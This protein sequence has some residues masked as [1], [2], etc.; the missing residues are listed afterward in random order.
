MQSENLTFRRA[1]L[2]ALAA[3]ANA[4][5]A[6][7]A[8]SGSSLEE[9]VVTGTRIPIID[10]TVPN[11]TMSISS[12]SIQLSG[13]TNLT[14]LLSNMPALVGSQDTTQNSGSLAGIGTT[15]LNLLNLRNLGTD[16][17]LV[18]VDGRRHVAQVPESAAVD[19]DTIPIDLVE[20]V[21]VATGGVSAVYG[22]DAVSGVVNFI[23]K[24]DF[25]GVSARAQYGSGDSGKPVNTIMSLTAGTN[26]AEGR[27]N[28]S[29]SFEVTREG[30]L[31][32]A[33]R[34]YLS[35]ANY[36]RLTRLGND[37]P[38][39]SNL[40]DRVALNNIR[41]Y[42]DSREGGIDVGFTGVP[43][44]RPDGSLYDPGNI[45]PGGLAQGGNGTLVADYI[46]DVIAGTKN[47]IAS[48]FLHYEFSDRAKLFGELKYAHGNSYS[49]SQPTFDN[50]VY[51]TAENPY[52]S[53][54]ITA[55][56]APGSGASNTGITGAPDGVLFDRDNFD[57]G[58]RAERINR[59][60]VRSVLG[61]NG[62]VTSN[63]SYEMS[64]TYGQT[65]VHNLQYN[66]RLNDRF[67][68]ALDVVTD[69]ATGKPTCRSNLNPTALPFQPFATSFVDFTG[70]L[71]FTPGPGSGCLPLNLFGEGVAD[72][73]AVAW[74]FTNP[75]TT[76]KL[77]QNVF[78]AFVNGQMPALKLQGGAI[79]YV[80]GVEWRRETSETNPPVIDQTGLTFGNALFPTKGAFDVKE[81][82]GEIR[83]PL[84]K[85]KPFADSLALSGAIR[86]S[87]YSTVGT[88]TTWNLGLTWAPV[89]DVSFRGT[90]AQSVRA[91][92][93]GEL[94]APASQT[95]L[96]IDDPC[97]I[98]RL[99]NGTKYRT[100]NC[101]AILSALGIDP[102]TFIDTATTN[103]SGLQSGNPHL[104]Q[105]TA[106]SWTA[107]VVLQPRFIADLAL[108][109]DVYDIKINNA[110]NTPAAQDLA[111][112]CVDQ[113]T[114][115]NVFCAALTRSTTTGL[116][117]SFVV[118]PH[119][120]ANFHTTGFDFNLNYSL[121]PAQHGAG[122]EWGK[123]VFTVV[124]G[125][126][127]RLT[128]IKSPGAAVEDDRTTQYAPLW[129]GSFDLAWYRGPLTI[130][131]N[132]SY[133]S[134]TS[135]VPLNTLAGD[136]DYA[137]AKDKY[138]ESRHTQDL[139]LSIETSKQLRVYAGVNNFT[140]QKPYLSTYYPV[141]P[142][143][144]YV[145]V[146]IKYGAGMGTPGR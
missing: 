79:Q 72:P 38:D 39:P 82:F 14:Q 117:K 49:E 29:G 61:V 63:M 93:I 130:N 8:D 113:P 97:D 76:S 67:Y 50:N 66:D 112:N 42:T 65:K 60:T 70:P 40:P 7:A 109:V 4:P 84:L 35:G 133:F 48:G 85:H 143:G 71:T 3:G 54:I 86:E 127:N 106:K 68:A 62:K 43:D 98:S 122:A 11:P 13:S 81:A 41:Y 131:Y 119:N 77:T 134:P 135:R 23:M 44:H 89:K 47:T 6:L 24:K 107:G 136:P 126:L 132:Y 57:L 25:Q 90:L 92:N 16:R 51:I 10:A 2:L 116:I 56:I 69:P 52:L 91:P 73:K 21:D 26:F 1:V 46:G 96:F 114:I 36:V 102:T 78:N 5:M 74:I 137:S 128:F 18:L 64:Y 15:G 9:I 19:I 45:L 121:N 142:Q 125:R 101:A 118:E 111:D 105:E 31:R 145:F 37:P 129:Q 75:V 141:S 32:A 88:T 123:F 95:F 30:R 108:S 20:R 94:F 17:T 146:G 59:D 34:D 53:P 103:I 120:V 139:Q 22:A 138:Y 124:G 100:A 58:T 28:I 87:N 115:N 144:R 140:N 110:V 104:K 55:L 80:M 27:G 33:D 99:A 83:L 12:E